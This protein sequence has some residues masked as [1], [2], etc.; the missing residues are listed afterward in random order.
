M[1]A[2]F[3]IVLRTFLNWRHSGNALRAPML[4]PKPSNVLSGLRSS[5]K[6]RGLKGLALAIVED[7]GIVE[8][9]QLRQG[10]A[11]SCV[12]GVAQRAPIDVELGGVSDQFLSAIEES[13]EDL[14]GSLNLLLFGH[15]VRSG[16]MSRLRRSPK[17]VD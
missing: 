5:S 3:L 8:V 12:R 4:M 9:S 10:G 17:T 7:H 1:T 15:R 16:V 2:F 6:T 13:V 14:L 11:I